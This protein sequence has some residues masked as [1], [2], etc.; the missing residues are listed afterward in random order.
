M[1]V[2]CPPLII[3]LLFH[4]Y[5]YR[6]RVSGLKRKV[7]NIGVRYI[8]HLEGDQ[9]SR[10]VS[11]I[12][13]ECETKM[14]KKDMQKLLARGYGHIFLSLEGLFLDVL[15]CILYENIIF[16]RSEVI[17]ASNGIDLMLRIWFYRR[18]VRQTN[19][20]FVR[21]NNFNI[22]IFLPSHMS[23]EQLSSI[24]NFI[25]YESHCNPCRPAALQPYI[26]NGQP[27]RRI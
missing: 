23:T 26:H 15:T 2:I 9:W 7:G 3:T 24:T 20:V 6:K 1:S 17:K 19:S 16:M 27:A 22:D 14:N 12:N 18:I 13:T 21:N 10:Y 11:H 8:I 4:C 25:T 5:A